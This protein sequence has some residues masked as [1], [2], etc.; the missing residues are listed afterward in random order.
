MNLRETG[1]RERRAL[2]VRAVGRGHVGA[3]GVRRE[4][5]DVAV[6]A[7]RE[8]H[9]VG[10]VRLDRAGHHVAHDDATRLAVDDDELE[11]LVAL[12]HRHAAARDLLLERLVCAEQQLLAGLPARVEGARDL[13]AAERTVGEESA[14]LT[15]EGH[16]LCDALVDDVHRD[17]RETVHVRLARAEVT[18]LHR[19]VEQP[20]H[21]VAVITVVLRRVDAALRRDGVRAAR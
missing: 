3:L 6:A 7:R 17:L 18:A 12:V 16:A 21:G 2:L 15:R 19:V 4:I 11:H 1:I 8:D 14:V 13:R 9:R 20:L 10:H 5:E